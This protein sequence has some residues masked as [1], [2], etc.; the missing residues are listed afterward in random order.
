MVEEKLEVVVDLNDAKNWKTKT[1]RRNFEGFSNVLDC[2]RC[3]SKLEMY[4]EV[5]IN[6]DWYGRGEVGR[7]GC[8]CDSCLD[9]EFGDRTE[10]ELL[11]LVFERWNE[12]QTER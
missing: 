6:G 10:F 12:L 1:E 7:V 8:T 11:S 9:L 4:L 3:G 5:P 2:K